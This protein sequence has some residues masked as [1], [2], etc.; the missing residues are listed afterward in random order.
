M[1]MKADLDHPLLDK[2][3]GFEEDRFLDRVEFAM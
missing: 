2:I 3:V 1:A